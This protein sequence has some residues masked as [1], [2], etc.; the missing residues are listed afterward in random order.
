MYNQFF[1]TLATSTIC[2]LAFRLGLLLIGL[3]N[4]RGYVC[5]P[6][7]P[8]LSPT[9]TLHPFWGSSGWAMTG[10]EPRHRLVPLFELSPSRLG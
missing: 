10:V 7:A 6:A 2:H 1:V 5:E 4:S 8:E 9:R 3:R